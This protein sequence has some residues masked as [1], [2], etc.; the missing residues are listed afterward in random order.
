MNNNTAVKTSLDL[1]LLEFITFHNKNEIKGDVKNQ[2]YE[3]T[4]KI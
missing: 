2:P 1:S 4:E 3:D